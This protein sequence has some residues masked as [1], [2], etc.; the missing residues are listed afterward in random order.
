M[1][2]RCITRPPQRLPYPSPDK[3]ISSHSPHRCY[4][5]LKCKPFQPNDPN[6]LKEH[7]GARASLVLVLLLS[8]P[9]T[10]KMSPSSC[11]GGCSDD[12]NSAGSRKTLR[13]ASRH[14]AHHA[15][16][17]QHRLAGN[18]GSFSG[19]L[20]RRPDLRRHPSLLALRA[21]GA[22]CFGDGALGGGARTF[23]RAPGR[24]EV[25]LE[26]APRV[27]PGRV[28]KGDFADAA[29]EINRRSIL[30]RVRRSCKLP[31]SDSSCARP[32]RSLYSES[33]GNRDRFV[34]CAT[35]Q[36][37]DRSGW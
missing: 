21:F 17:S 1:H 11:V 14:F 24:G 19:T 2:E 8:T 9:D 28:T 5:P 6:G 29:R 25:S 4:P 18:S 32:F 13:Y 27:H 34:L 3:I 22:L 7:F 10:L 37:G 16:G 35:V 20:A 23:P 31:H 12:R 15:H 36:D 33:R 30:A 26:L